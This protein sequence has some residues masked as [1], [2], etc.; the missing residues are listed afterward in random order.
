MSS[1]PLRP[2]PLAPFAIALGVATTTAAAQTLVPIDGPR[3]VDHNVV[4]DTVHQ[5][6][7]CLDP[8]GELWILDG[9]AALRRARV[10]QPT[11]LPR[12]EPAMVFATTR[13]ELLLFGGFGTGG[14]LGDTWTWDGAEW[15]QQQG[16]VTPPRRGG[17]A[18]AWDESR[19]RV[20]MFG[21]T[22]TGLGLVDTWEHDGQGW[23]Q[24]SPTLVPPF[25]LDMRMCYDAAR[26]VSVLVGHPPQSQ[27][28]EWN[29]VDW[30][31]RIVQGALP[32]AFGGFHLAYDPARQR[33]VLL[34]GTANTIA[35]EYDGQ[36]WT[37]A[38]ADPALQIEHG[39]A[40]Y[41]TRTGRIELAGGST[42]GAQRN[43]RWAWNGSSVAL[44]AQTSHAPGEPGALCQWDPSSDSI[45]RYGGYPSAP[46]HVA[47]TFDG[48][49]W[50]QAPPSGAAPDVYRTAAASDSINRRILAFGGLDPA[51]PH[52]R[53]L[54]WRLGAWN[55]LPGGPPARH[56][57]MLAVDEVRNTVV[58][59]G[60]QSGST[61]PELDDT[62]E[63]TTTGA[64][65]Q[66]QP[67]QHPSRRTDAAMVFDG[68]RGRTVMYGGFTTVGA[69]LP[70]TWEWDGVNWSQ[71]A[72]AT[73]P[74]GRSP[75]MTYDRRNGRLLML[76]TDA[77][78][79]SEQVWTFDGV[80]WSLVLAAPWRFQSGFAHDALR[81][82]TFAHGSA[83]MFELTST[84]RDVSV[85]GAG[86]GALP[87]FD[88]R[89]APRLGEPEFG[90]EI[91]ARAP[92][93]LAMFALS[94][95]LGNAPIGGGCTVHLGAIAATGVLVSDATGLAT[96][97]VPLRG[98]P[99]LRGATFF[100]QAATLD[101]A[102]GALS[103]SRALRITVG[104]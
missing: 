38:G 43:E 29:G 93:T 67:L 84:P 89:A 50:R 12:T 85:V 82:R 79:P 45:L 103:L 15:H 99:A 51:G 18:I 27:I 87:G 76:T 11:P 21:G 97:R 73:Q 56:G 4:Y 96:A 52:G 81:G 32:S 62:W 2:V 9:A 31:V 58:L 17:A 68:A 71:R 34:G 33:T 70:E 8:G 65:Q 64:W 22:D 23:Q 94:A 48:S 90:F 63:F 39:A 42:V 13:R 19:D 49:T 6:A 86:C 5:R 10:T 59:F 74:T 40:W 104:D 54:E 30:T 7:L 46:T 53:F 14:P 78:Q 102:T 95:T 47:W 36:S 66:R 69:F 44:V 1:H 91:D 60:G 77:N 20:V 88:V 72:V 98:T 55:P 101:A 100:A 83:G 41:D 3:I 37:I 28:H 92:A 75:L 25:A 26:S 35:Y 16:A 61:P 24:R 57:A 80:D